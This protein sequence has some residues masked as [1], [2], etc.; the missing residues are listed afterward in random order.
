MQFKVFQN[1]TLA[2]IET[3]VNTWLATG[4]FYTYTQSFTMVP[5][6]GGGEDFCLSIFYMEK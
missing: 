6:G 5:D 3:A 4:T 2:G 1:A